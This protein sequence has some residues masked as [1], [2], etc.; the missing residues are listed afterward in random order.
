VVAEAQYYSSTMVDHES[1]MRPFSSERAIM[2]NPNDPTISDR[3]KGI[4]E[5]LIRTDRAEHHGVIE[6]AML[7]LPG[8]GDAVA[9]VTERWPLARVRDFACDVVVFGVERRA[10]RGQAR[11][12]HDGDE[13]GDETVL[14]RGRARAVPR[15]FAD[16]H[17]HDILLVELNALQSACLP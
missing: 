7:Q 14:D 13:R 15:K 3:A 11:C 9:N 16:V 4:A 10:E 2:T 1:G 8:R 6:Q 12:R 5:E 17:D